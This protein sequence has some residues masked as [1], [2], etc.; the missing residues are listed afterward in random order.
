MLPRERWLVIFFSMFA[1][2]AA[3]QTF[4]NSGNGM[5]RGD[6]F[7]RQVLLSDIS[8]QGVIGR[9]RGILGTATFDGNGNYAFSGQIADTQMAQPQS[10]SVNGKYIL[11]SNGLFQMQNPIDT[12]DTD[13][14]GVGAAGPSAIVASATEGSYHDI[15]VAIPAGSSFSTSN[16]AG[17]FSAGFVDF[18]GGSSAKA[19]DG[20]FSFN[21][22]GQGSLGNLPI[23][24][25]AADSGNIP[26]TQTA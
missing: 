23:N 7:V 15:L 4:D 17:A 14:G 1:S 12:T 13:Y 10:Y 3:A 25:A 22:N 5:L 20:Y 2:G 21:S 8:A 6:Y 11:A 18:T 16:L 24:G 26:S 19:R 9:A